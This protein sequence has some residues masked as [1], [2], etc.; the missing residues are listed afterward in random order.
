MNADDQKIAA[1]KKELA[2]LE[3]KKEKERRIAVWA[4]VKTLNNEDLKLLGWMIHV[5]FHGDGEDD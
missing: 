1:L 3:S 2:D 5:H 4:C